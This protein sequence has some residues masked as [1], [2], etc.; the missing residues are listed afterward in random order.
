MGQSV[1]QSESRNVAAGGLTAAWVLGALDSNLEGVGRFPGGI[2]ELSWLVPLLLGFL[3]TITTLPARDS[4]FLG[5][6]HQLAR[7]GR[8]GSAS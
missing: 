8:E 2:S 3:V 6:H 4:A 7:G 1:D 5:H